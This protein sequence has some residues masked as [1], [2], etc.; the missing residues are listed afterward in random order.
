VNRTLAAM[1]LAGLFLCAGPSFSF[2]QPDSSSASR[3]AISRAAATR[4]AKLDVPDL[5]KGA[6]DPYDQAAQRTHFFAAAGVDGELD[7][8][9]FQADQAR[10]NSFVRPFDRWAA[11]LAFDKN[12]NKTLDWFEADAYRQDLRKKVLAHFD[13]DSDGRLAGAER[14]AANRALAAGRIPGRKNALAA[15][16]P[17]DPTGRRGASDPGGASGQAGASPDETQAAWKVRLEERRKQIL[18]KYDADG[19]GQLST[20]ERPAMNKDSRLRGQEDLNAWQLRHFDADGDGQLS[21]AEKADQARFQK[22]AQKMG[23]ELELKLLDADGDG[24]ISP[25]ERAAGQAEFRKV[26]MM[27]LLKMNQ[28]MDIDGDGKVTAG[29]RQAFWDNARQA[30]QKKAEAV[31]HQYDADGNGRLDEDERTAMLE[32]IKEDLQSRMDK[33][34]ADADGRLDAQ[35]MMILLEDLGKEMD[36]LPPGPPSGEDPSAAPDTPPAGDAPPARGQ[37]PPATQ[38]EHSD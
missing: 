7:A 14:D 3:P 20:E 2:A 12:Q 21:D 6:V 15:S 31:T 28:Y 4:P 10:P 24:Q 34:D 36:M 25:E 33:Y 26:G 1:T 17:A 11:M 37:N 18:A 8:N 30:I 22:D 29:E 16:R 23:K 19:D 32:G 35:E 5:C 27:M 13:A 9:E 38:P